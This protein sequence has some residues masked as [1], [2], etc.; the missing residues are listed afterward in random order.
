MTCVKTG[1]LDKCIVIG[2]VLYSAESITLA[3]L[4]IDHIMSLAD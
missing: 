3:V 1:Y 4:Y 2:I